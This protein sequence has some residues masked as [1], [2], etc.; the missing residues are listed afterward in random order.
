M[1]DVFIHE[2]FDYDLSDDSIYVSAAC[3][4]SASAASTGVDTKF[5]MNDIALLR[6]SKQS[7]GFH[8]CLHL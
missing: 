6:L 4:A 2:D 1:G 3:S 8:L 7:F 5:M